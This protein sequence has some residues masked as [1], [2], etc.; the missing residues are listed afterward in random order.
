MLKM[1]IDQT[2]P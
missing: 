2:D 1:Y